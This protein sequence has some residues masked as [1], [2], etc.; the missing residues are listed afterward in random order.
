[1]TA[2]KLHIAQQCEGETYLAFHCPACERDHRLHQVVVRT[3]GTGWKWNGSL[4][5]PTFEPSVLVNVGGMNPTAPIC[6]SFVRNGMIEFLSDCTHAMAGQT[7]EIPAWDS[8]S[9]EQ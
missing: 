6:H 9:E 4:D 1:M 7:V 8:H 2:D 5:R 3:N